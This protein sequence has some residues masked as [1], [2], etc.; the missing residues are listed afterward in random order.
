MTIIAT[1]ERLS[2]V[3]PEPSHFDALCEVFGNADAMRYI[4][5]GT[6]WSPGRIRSL[7]DKMV[8]LQNAHGFSLWPVVRRD[9][10]EVIGDCGFC[11]IRHSGSGEHGPEI[12]IGYHLRPDSWGRGYASEAAAA[13]LAYGFDALSLDRIVAVTRPENRASQHVLLKCGMQRVGETERFYD[14]R[15][16]LFEARSG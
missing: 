1:T 4:G 7:I 9:T 6:A 10:G 16:T 2:L 5:D 15:L 14:R 13:A 3:A 12:E 8:E 11:F